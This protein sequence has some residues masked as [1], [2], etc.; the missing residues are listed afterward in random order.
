[1]EQGLRARPS[2]PPAQ[3][4]STL[5]LI[6]LA[7][8][9]GVLPLI[10]GAALLFLRPAA[11][12]TPAG[13]EALRMLTGLSLLAVA[14]GPFLGRILFD[15]CLRQDGNPDPWAR[16]QAALI[17]RMAVLEGGAILGMAA[18]LFAALSGALQHQ[19]LYWI[20]ALGLLPFY[21]GLISNLPSQ[22]KLEEIM[23]QSG[24]GSP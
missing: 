2:A 3:I 4:V 23:R 18:C 5:R 20:N 24:E 19:P 10:G 8:G 6:F 22:Q 9:A 14:A 13:I 21:H 11:E 16:L 12:P 7:M 15:L 1:M 17:A